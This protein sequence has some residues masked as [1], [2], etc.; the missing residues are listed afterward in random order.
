MLHKRCS[1]VTHAS[2][3]ERMDALLTLGI[4]S[5]VLFLVVIIVDGAIR[6][7][8]RP[9]R[10]AISAL[11]LGPRGRLQTINFMLTGALIFAASFGVSQAGASPWLAIAVA[12]VGIGMIGSGTFAMDPMRGYPPGTPDTTPDEVSREHQIHDW[13]GA[14]VFMGLPFAAISA[15]FTLEPLPWQVFSAVVAVVLLGLLAL[16]NAQYARDSPRAGLVQRLVVAVGHTWL[17]LVCW[18]LLML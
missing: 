12:M 3:V 17:S 2:T 13:V 6:P 9:M 5:P 7:G 16:F 8:Y 18:H 4:V 10:H 11:A 14:L 1:L 15:A